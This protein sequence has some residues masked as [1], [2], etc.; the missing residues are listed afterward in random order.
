MYVVFRCP[1]CTR[2]LYAAAENK[3]RRCVCGRSVNLAKVLVLTRCED[4]RKAGDAVRNLQ[5]AGKEEPRFVTYG[6]RDDE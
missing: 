3:T 1:G 2:Y 6:H 5:A 4:E